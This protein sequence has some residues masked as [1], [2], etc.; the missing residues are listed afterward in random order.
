MKPL[1]SL[2]RLPPLFFR[3]GPARHKGITPAPRLILAILLFSFWA[4]LPGRCCDYKHS[5]NMATA[6]NNCTALVDGGGGGG[7]AVWG[8]GLVFGGDEEQVER[9]GRAG[10]GG[11]RVGGGLVV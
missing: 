2:S 11:F 3:S 1:L 10:G 7:R 8:G 5:K 6:E 4:L 9:G